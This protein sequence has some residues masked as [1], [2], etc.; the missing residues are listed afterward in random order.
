MKPLY[1][2][3]FSFSSSLFRNQPPSANDSIKGP[4]TLPQAKQITPL[5]KI[6]QFLSFTM[7]FHH[8]LRQ[9]L[10]INIKYFFPGTMQP[11]L[12]ETHK[13]SCEKTSNSKDLFFDRAGYQIWYMCL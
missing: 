13:T 4:I 7:L 3:S 6:A 12:P 5:Q 9:I 10:G 2:F 8:Y 1:I 11:P